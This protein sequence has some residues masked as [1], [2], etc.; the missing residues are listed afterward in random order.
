[1]NR[2]IVRYA[3]LVAAVIGVVFAWVVSRRILLGGNAFLP[4]GV[5]AAAVWAV[6]VPVFIICWPRITISGFRRAIARRGLGDGP[7]P[8]NT[9]SATPTTASPGAAGSALLGTGTEDL[10]YVGGWLD[11][12]TTPQILHT[13][14][15]TGRYYCLQLIDPARSANFAYIGTRATGSGEGD[16]L[17]SGPGWSGTVPSGMTQIVSPRASVLVI[18]R[19]L[20]ENERDLP[21]A[22]ALAQRLR[23]TPLGR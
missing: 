18:G 7:I 10:L 9:L 23:L 19:V 1:M 13:P 20:V 11:L 22:H 4:L 6:G 15:M 14:D 17:L 21:A 5:A 12:R 2:L 16:Y 8:V 3:P